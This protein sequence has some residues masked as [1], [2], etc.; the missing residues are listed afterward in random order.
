MW[1]GRCRLRFWYVCVCVCVG[2]E[3]IMYERKSK[4]S[5][6]RPR[7][8]YLMKAPP[9]DIRMLAVFVDAPHQMSNN[10]SCSVYP[11]Y[12]PTHYHNK[13]NNRT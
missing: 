3:R 8:G 9:G 2:R 12:Q 1:V 6:R 7:G 5:I 11:T 10:M 4:N 13:N